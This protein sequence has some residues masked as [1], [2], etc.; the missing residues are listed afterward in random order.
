MLI[1]Q[2]ARSE[3]RNESVKFRN[4]NRRNGSPVFAAVFV[5]LEK[6]AT[7]PHFP[8]TSV[9]AARLFD[10]VKFRPALLHN[11]N[12]LSLSLSL[13]LS[14][15]AVFF[16]L[17]SFSLPFFFSQSSFSFELHDR[18]TCVFPSLLF[19]FFFFCFNYWR[20]DQIVVSLC[21]RSVDWKKYAKNNSLFS[22]NK[23][24]ERRSRTR[25]STFLFAGNT[26]VYIF[27]QKFRGT[28]CAGVLNVRRELCQLRQIREKYFA[29]TASFFLSFMI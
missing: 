3:L 13:S 15:L 4:R 7:R 29:K 18:Q 26:R 6:L 28:R 1:K 27:L 19:F 20:K 23:I 11:A 25:P 10:L 5:T 17:F 12:S 24:T 9:Y 8:A 22:C 2:K 21:G 16:L 14:W